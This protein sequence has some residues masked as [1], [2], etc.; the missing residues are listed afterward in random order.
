MNHEEWLER[1]EIYA[2]GSLEGEELTEFEAHRAS[3]CD[4][5]EAHLRETRETLTLL[6]RSLAPLNPPPTVKARLLQQIGGE[7]A[8][9]IREIQWSG[10][11]WWGVGAGALAA[12]SLLI[13]LGWNLYVNL[14]ELQ[15]LEGRVAALQT[16][17]AQ[18]EETLRFLSDPQVRFILLAGLPPSP[19]ATGRLLWNPANRTGLF[20]T[21]G[22]PLTPRNRA[23]ELWAISGKEPIPAGVFKVDQRGRA[24]FRLPPLVEGKTF[25]KF[26]VT[27]EPAGGVLNPTGPMYLLGSP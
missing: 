26:A 17:V 16:K 20:L 14:Q 18:Q 8:P 11:P 19:E 9:P 6:P 13:T 2:L 5:C 22:L 21:T 3:G 1:A 27:L 24:I 23:Y 7:A 15:K 10:W 25:D 12:A 4:L